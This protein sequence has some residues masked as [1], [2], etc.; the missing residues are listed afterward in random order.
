MLSYWCLWVNE[1]FLDGISAHNRPF[2]CLCGDQVE[3]TVLPAWPAIG[4]VF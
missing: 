2:Q 4:I 3:F 1:Q